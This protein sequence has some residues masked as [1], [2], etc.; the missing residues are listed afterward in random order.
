MCSRHVS[1]GV[2][3]SLSTI[4]SRRLAA[5]P[6]MTSDRVGCLPGVAGVVH[7]FTTRR[8]VERADT[9]DSRTVKAKRGT[10]LKTSHVS[11]RR[12]RGE[13]SSGE[14]SRRRGPNPA[15]F[16]RQLTEAKSRSDWQK[17]DEILAEALMC[18]GVDPVRICNATIAV[19]AKCGRWRQAVELLDRMKLEGMR[20]DAFTYSSTM[21]A[22]ASGSNWEK[23]LE[24]LEEMEKEGVQA[25][26]VSYTSAITAC[27]KGRQWEKALYLLRQM[28]EHGLVA[29][30]VTYG[31]AVAACAHSSRWE[32]AIEV[33]R[34]MEAAGVAPNVVIYAAAMKACANCARWREALELLEQMKV[35][36]IPA[37]VIS[38]TAAIKACGAGG[39]WEI[40]LNLF[41][42]MR[43]KGIIANVASY[44]AA[45]SGLEDDDRFWETSL[46][47]VS[48]V[49]VSR[50]RGDI[51]YS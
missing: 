40:A 18:A 43:E 24:L 15:L 36:E 37:N 10:E 8:A 35:K 2:R 48:Q 47:L 13:M 5:V 34:E 29:N 3:L 32:E 26:V 42:E 11:R 17:A 25:N 45:L 6:D 33:L 9:G 28:Q 21:D 4:R 30:V 49:R 19:Y 31:A 46:D 23:A 16:M 50:G 14:L 27:G 38:Y 44:D 7:T 1:N 39:Q 20:P 51:H 22:C 41:R 12:S